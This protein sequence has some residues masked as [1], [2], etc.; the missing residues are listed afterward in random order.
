MTDTG[1]CLT[2]ETV[3]TDGGQVLKGFQF[4][5]REPLTE[6]GHVIFLSDMISEL[7]H[8]YVFE[9]RELTLIP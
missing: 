4:R 3:C 6:D 2:P 7:S 5:G 9:V 8:W 1:Q